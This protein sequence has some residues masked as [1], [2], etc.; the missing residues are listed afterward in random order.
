MLKAV[1]IINTITGLSKI[2]EYYNKHTMTIVNFFETMLLNRYP[3]AIEITYD[4]G[5]E[6]ICNDFRSEV[7]E[8]EYRN[9][10]K[11]R[12]L[13]NPTSN[14]KM[15]R[16]YWVLCNFVRDYIIQDTYVD[17]DYP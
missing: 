10:V 16:I 5:S 7:I 2:L 9:K 13:G 11:P 4:Q 15:K 6:F 8:E 1:T 12:S 14:E 3:C 17:M